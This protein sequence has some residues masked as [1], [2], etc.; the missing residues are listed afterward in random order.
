MQVSCVALGAYSEEMVNSI[1]IPKVRLAL[2]V[3]SVF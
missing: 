3:C 1:G 2:A